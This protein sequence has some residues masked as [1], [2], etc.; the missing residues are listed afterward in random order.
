MRLAW[1]RSAALWLPALG[2]QPSLATGV[3]LITAL[4]ARFIPCLPASCDGVGFVCRF[5]LALA[6]GVGHSCDISVRFPDIIVRSLHLLENSV[7]LTVT[8]HAAQRT[9]NPASSQNMSTIEQF[10]EQITC[11]PH[12]AQNNLRFRW[13]VSLCP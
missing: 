1:V 2:F 11:V 7:S 9:C 8:S 4:V 5:S 13:V 6:R 12:T 10:D 3:G